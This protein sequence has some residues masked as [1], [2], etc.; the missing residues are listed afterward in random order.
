MVAPYGGATGSLLRPGWGR[1]GRG[2]VK[3]ISP[4]LP[5]HKRELSVLDLPPV[6]HPRGYRS[7]FSVSTR[8]EE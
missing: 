7:D 2:G 4:A 3:V 5:G 8:D 1:V 6:P